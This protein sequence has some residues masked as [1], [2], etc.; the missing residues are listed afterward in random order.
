MKRFIAKK[1]QN[2]QNLEGDIINNK[3]KYDDLINL[4]IGDPD[5]STPT[6]L[7]E[8]AYQDTLNG[9]TGYAD[10]RGYLELR[11]AISLFY[12]NKYNMQINIDEVLVT[13]AATA[14]L[15]VALNAVLNE[16]DEVIVIEPYFFPYLSQIEINGGKAVILKTTFEDEYQIN[17]DEL[18]KVVTDKTKVILINSPNNP[19]GVT[20]TKSTLEKLRDFVIKRDLLVIADDIYTSFSF[21]EKFIPIS[22]L[23]G[24]H[25]RCITINS[26]SK[27]L[28]MT[29]L[30][31]GNIVA[32]KEIISVI[33]DVNDNVVYSAPSFSQRAA[34]HG[35]LNFDKIEK[36]VQNIFKER[37]EYVYSRI[38]KIDFLDVVKTYGSFYVFPN[39]K[40]TGLKSEEF[41]K[42]LLE[43]AHILVLPGVM[44]GKSGDDNFRISCT[45]GI[46]KL[47]EAFDRI[48]K[49]KF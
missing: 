31:V 26:F 20:Y 23:E 45:V 46:D 3:D 27:N 47:K 15:Y 4:S 2:L 44:F 49:M 43:Q 35:L 28:V 48:E 40:K 24:M 13:A 16:G 19:T 25:E 7:L 18:N 32:P 8:K 41:S 34:L 39:I 12:K 33:R 29:G 30:R 21:K 14:G 11:E 37:L 36:E 17:F 38:D 5:I 22:S 10:S 9:Y 6:E 1:Y 42:K